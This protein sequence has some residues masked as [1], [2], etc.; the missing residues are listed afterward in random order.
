MRTRLL[1]IAALDIV[2]LIG[3]FALREANIFTDAALSLAVA[4]IGIDEL[5][6][7]VHFVGFHDVSRCP[8]EICPLYSV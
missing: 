5:T 7:D 3:G 1:A 4:A 6:A 2:I 8:S